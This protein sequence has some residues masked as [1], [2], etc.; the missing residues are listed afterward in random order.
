MDEIMK[1]ID[2]LNRE[3]NVMAVLLGNP[4]ASVVMIQMVDDHDLALIES[5]VEEIKRLD[6]GMIEVDAGRYFREE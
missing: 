6:N 1:M 5:E 3:R 4:D 2:I